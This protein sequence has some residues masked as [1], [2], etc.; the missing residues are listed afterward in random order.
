MKLSLL[1]AATSAL[2]VEN[3]FADQAGD[4]P[5]GKC[6]KKPNWEP[7]CDDHPHHHSWP[8]TYTK[9]HTVYLEPE[10]VCVTST[11]TYYQTRTTDGVV[12]FTSSTSVSTT[13]QSTTVTSTT[14]SYKTIATSTRTVTKT[15][16]IPRPRNLLPGKDTV[17]GYPEYEH[18]N[19]KRDVA[20]VAAEVTEA[21]EAVPKGEKNEWPEHHDH[22]HG[23][24][25]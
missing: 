23:T 5:H 14:T 19:W 7:P 11:R 1:F 25:I 21:A 9:Y 10:T 17:F 8:A 22:H 15:L 13:R 12:R 18:E 4:C 2:L 24:Q 20:E 3:A 6:N 16:T